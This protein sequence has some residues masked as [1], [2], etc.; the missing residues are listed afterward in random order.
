MTKKKSLSKSLSK[1]FGSRAEVYHGTSKKTTGGLEKDNLIKNKH[2]YIVSKKKST[3]MKK[4]PNKNPLK[5]FLQKKNSKKFGV[6][7][8]CATKNT[9]TTKTTKTTKKTKKTIWNYLFS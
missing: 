9:K 3:F 5:C 4:N 8:D 2:G 6:N 7:E 1:T